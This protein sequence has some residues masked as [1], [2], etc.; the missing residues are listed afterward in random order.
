MDVDAVGVNQSNLMDSI[1][2]LSC[3]PL[4]AYLS[5]GILL[6]MQNLQVFYDLVIQNDDV[7]LLISLSVSLLEL[8][9]LSDENLK[10][11]MFSLLIKH[12]IGVFSN[13]GD[14]FSEM[15]DNRVSHELI[16]FIQLFFN[17]YL[18]DLSTFSVIDIDHFLELILLKNDYLAQ[19]FLNSF[20]P[21]YDSSF[22]QFHEFFKFV[23]CRKPCHLKTVLMNYCKKLIPV[24]I[25][26][27]LKS[28]NQTIDSLEDVIEIYFC[29]KQSSYST[30][31]F[32]FSTEILS[33]LFRE[34]DPSTFS[35]LYSPLPL[36]YLNIFSNLSESDELSTVDESLSDDD[37]SFIVMSTSNLFCSLSLTE[38]LL[39]HKLIE[40]IG[41]I[42]AQI[43]SNYP[44]ELTIKFLNLIGSERVQNFQNFSCPLPFV[45]LR[46]S[47]GIKKQLSDYLNTVERIPLSSCL[48]SSDFVNWLSNFRR[49]FDLNDAIISSQILTIISKNLNSS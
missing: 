12:A 7:F 18:H 9:S 49:F 3:C 16:I 39:N 45:P 41:F 43:S 35:F 10:F 42:T 2:K 20:S 47:P 22:Q 31:S 44:L 46:N 21:D 14:I 6:L 13:F 36:K 32:I 5:P 26:F 28:N 11:S 4:K 30:S 19:L 29:K 25:I 34:I 24:W 37:V 38:L 15:Q 8:L 33:E 1:N 23:Q 48:N 27:L 17:V 40:D